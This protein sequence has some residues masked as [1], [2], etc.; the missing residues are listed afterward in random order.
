MARDLTQLNT[1]SY[2]S[3]AWTSRNTPQSEELLRVIM[4]VRAWGYGGKMNE[5]GKR[6]KSVAGAGLFAGGLNTLQ[7]N[8][9]LLCNNRCKHCHLEAGPEK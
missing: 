1:I 3:A 5:F 6:I 9:G 8:I 7:V 2:V 4:T